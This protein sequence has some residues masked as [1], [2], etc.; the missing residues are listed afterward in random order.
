MVSFF[1]GP[2][3][4]NVNFDLIDHWLARSSIKMEIIR[5]QFERK[6]QPNKSLIF[7]QRIYDY[8]FKILYTA[9]IGPTLTQF[10]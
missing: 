2:I 3:M 6:E 7:Y 4:K 5:I 9:F 10:W 1:N 8:G